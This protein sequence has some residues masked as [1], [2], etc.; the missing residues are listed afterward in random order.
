MGWPFRPILHNSCFFVFMFALGW[1]CIKM[2]AI[3]VSIRN[4]SAKPMHELFLDLYVVCAVLML[5]PRKVRL[6]VKA[7]LCISLYSIALVDM[8][9][10]EHFGSPLTS[11]M[12]MLAGETTRQET[13]EFL[14]G[15]IT[16]DAMK[17]GVR[18]ILLMVLAHLLWTILRPLTANMRKRLIESLK[19]RADIVTGIKAVLG[20]MVI[21]LLCISVCQTWNNKVMMFRIFSYDTIGQVESRL[22][23]KENR[24][25]LYLPVYRLA[26]SIYTNSL[27]SKQIVR[28][29]D[30][31][32]L[33]KVDSCSYR[34]P[35]IVLVIGESYNKHHSQLYGYG[36]PVTPKQKAL[37]EEGSLVPFT[38]VVAPWNL[39]S[40]VFKYMFSLYA[41][42]DNGEWCDSPLF[43]EVF[44]K[45][46]YHVTF[47]TN[48]F[49]PDVKKPISDFSGGFFLNKQELSQRQF[50][51]R[52]NRL[53]RYDDGVLR[54]YDKLSK[55]NTD[56][57][58]IILHL[59]GSHMK[60]KMRYPKNFKIMTSKMYQHIA[61]RS[62]QRKIISEYDNSLYYNDSIVTAV[63]QRFMDK[64]A[65]VIYV[66]DHGEEVYDDGHMYGRKH[67]EVNYHIARYEM[68]IPFWIWGSP[69]FMEKH[70][71]DWQ[72]IRNAKDRPMMTDALPHLL[73]YLGG[74]ST[75]LYRE[76]LNVI[77]PAYNVNRPRI[78]RGETDY[79]TLRK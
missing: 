42:G 21:C 38:D 22:I 16:P 51:K 62:N 56:H 29:E 11:A 57:N 17:T 15:F 50:D 72:A 53:H 30:A 69:Q 9:C 24:P 3:P 52:N 58:L 54:E 79:N 78:L 65:L 68:E 28:L 77:S 5:I 20:C 13:R 43:P 66:P 26:F 34:V 39:T 48:Q 36:M 14:S 71:D 23:A 32:R 25:N 2:E 27:T 1:L 7:L 35:N 12:V 47:V 55:K 49:M 60:Y 10:Y 46:G 63:T 37:A 18:S 31:S 67:S 70:P 76:E 44:R 8:F 41:I 33:V 45:A 19:I 59:M 4:E 64:D 6:W 74:I 40:Y 75:P 73:L 61:L